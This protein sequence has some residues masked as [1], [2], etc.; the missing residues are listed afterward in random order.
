MGLFRKAYQKL[1]KKFR[2]YRKKVEQ[3]HRDRAERRKL[4]AE[5]ER[6]EFLQQYYVEMCETLPVEKNVVLVESRHGKGMDESVMKLARLFCEKEQF[7][8]YAVCVSEQ[9]KERRK[10]MDANGMQKMNLLTFSTKAYYKTLATAGILINEDNF[11]AAF[12][13]RPEQKFLRIWNSTPVNAIG[14][15]AREKFGMIGNAQRN[16]LAADYLLCPNRFTM[17]LLEKE[18][19]LA[20]IAKTTVLLSGR[21]ENAVFLENTTRNRLRKEYGW[22]EKQVFAYLPAL[23][24]YEG[25]SKKAYEEQLAGYLLTLEERLSE[26]QLIIIRV[27]QGVR[28]RLEIEN[29]QHIQWMPDTATSY[30]VLSAVDGLITDYSA[31]MMDYVVSGRKIIRFPF[32]EEKFRSGKKRYQKPEEFPFPV[33]KTA[34]E[35]AEELHK[36]IQYDAGKFY[37]TYASCVKPGMAEAVWKRVTEGK[38]DPDLEES[39]FSDNGKKNVLIYAGAFPKNGITTAIHNMLQQ[40]DT[41]KKNYR[42]YYRMGALEHNQEELKKLPEKVTYYG[43][44]RVDNL[45][46]RDAVLYAKWKK[47]KEFP[48]TKIQD[49]LQK[50]AKREYYR[51]LAFCRVEE[52]IQFDGYGEEITLLMEQMP[53]HRTIFA[54]NDMEMELKKKAFVRKEVLRHAYQTYDNVAIVTKDLEPSVRRVAEGKANIRVAK[55]V[56]DFRKIERLGMERLQTDERT[57]SNVSEERLNQILQSEAKKFITVG[58]FS[59]EKGHARLMEAFAQVQQENP[60]IYLILLGGYG[61]LYEETREKAEKMDCADRIIIIKYLSNPYPLIKA[62]DY[63]VLSSFYEGFGLVLAEADILGLPCFS[64]EITGPKLF[65]QQYGGKLVENSVQG[66]IHGMRDC[67]SGDVPKKLQIDYEVYNKEAAAQFEALTEAGEQE[68]FHKAE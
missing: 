2:N 49:I 30:Q 8:L 33:V 63:F 13:K 46:R 7:R 16:L 14:K 50:R 9:R 65:L 47:K 17:E 19:M 28:K 41:E 6:R 44:N 43:Y 3:W 52:V 15:S 20:N 10:W 5:K 35:L 36:G 61:P 66:I 24:D 34:E 45:S 55:N 12:I 62:C 26:Q 40:V 32:D 64:T 53:C 54:H 11:G 29:L 1:K 60:E 58:R 38:T 51:S 39:C 42:I 37:E 57:E 27:P 25:E 23:R 21:L 67:L 4:Q 48:Y 56:I 22:E 31:I 68:C 59:E 18:Y